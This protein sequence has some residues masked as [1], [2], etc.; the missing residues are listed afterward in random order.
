MR[1]DARCA[2]LSRPRGPGSQSGICKG[3]LL[4]GEF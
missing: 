4:D 2:A 1:F 3:V